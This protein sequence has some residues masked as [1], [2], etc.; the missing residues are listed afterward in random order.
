MLCVLS[1]IKFELILC[2]LFVLVR[3]R[4]LVRYG[5]IPMEYTETSSRG[6]RV[7]GEHEKIAIFGQHLALSRKDTR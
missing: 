7:Q 2:R 5:N 6:R 1:D 4:E 3:G